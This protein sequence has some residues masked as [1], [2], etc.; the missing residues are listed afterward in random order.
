MFFY[1]YNGGPIPPSLQGISIRSIIIDGDLVQQVKG[2]PILAKAVLPEKMK[3]KYKTGCLESILMKQL[4]YAGSVHNRISHAF[5]DMAELVRNRIYNSNTS[6]IAVHDHRLPSVSHLNEITIRALRLL[7]SPARNVEYDKIYKPGFFINGGTEKLT[8]TEAA[9]IVG[10]G[11]KSFNI[12]C[13]GLRDEFEAQAT[14]NRVERR[15]IKKCGRGSF[16]VSY[17][18]LSP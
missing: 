18:L 11:K 15:F 16:L 3:G 13:A 12:F 17:G 2:W 14:D 5:G 1:Q 4:T 6:I 8:L 10:G 9:K 7:R